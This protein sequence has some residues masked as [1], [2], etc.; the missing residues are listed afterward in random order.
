[1]LMKCKSVFFG[2]LIL[3]LSAAPVNSTE[4]QLY[5][6]DQRLACEALLC[7]TVGWGESECR[8]A[9]KKFF[10]IWTWKPSKLFSKR[11]NFLGLCPSGMSS[12]K[13]QLI[14]NYS[15]R[16]Q[17]PRFTNYVSAYRSYTTVETENG[18]SVTAS[19]RWYDKTGVWMHS[20][21]ETACRSTL[22]Y[23]DR[24]SF[25]S[26]DCAVFRDEFGIY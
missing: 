4:S 14:V 21:G 6:G 8:P 10:S 5:E 12:S 18:G 13:Q 19:C 3:F 22:S 25:A 9:I 15:G 7:L 24:L 26:R 2:F 16:C 17:G 23:A 20:Q 11:M 1:M